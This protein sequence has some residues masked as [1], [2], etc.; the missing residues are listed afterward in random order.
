ML[1]TTT[2]RTRPGFTLVELMV[3]AAVCVLIMAILA[4]VF[5]LSIDTMRQMKSTGDLMTQLR[6]AGEVVKRDLQADHFAEADN[7]NK[8]SDQSL[9]KLRVD[10][11]MPI[12][13]PPPGTPG[14]FVLRGWS[15]PANGGFFRIK[16]TP[17]PLTPTPGSAAVTEGQ[18]GDGLLS[19]RATDHYLH[20]TSI[21]D[22]S[23]GNPYTAVVN[24][25]PYTKRAAEIAYFLDPT[26]SGTTGGTGTTKL[27]HLIR[28][29]RLAATS[30]SDLTADPLPASDPAVISV[31]PSGANYVVNTLADL[32]N[33]NNRL[34]G[35][36][37]AHPKLAAG[38]DTQLATI[39]ASPNLI[40]DDILISNVI[41]FEVKVQWQAN[42]DPKLPTSANPVAFPGN[43][44]DPFDALPPVPTAGNTT[45]TGQRVFDSWTAGSTTMANPADPIWSDLD[46]T[47]GS[48]KAGAN[49]KPNA[50]PLLIRVKAVQIH[51]RVFDPKLKTTRQMTIVQDL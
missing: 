9:D 10:D 26:E 28:R 50:I 14:R 48:F 5:Q 19:S 45:L 27:Y 37:G 47:S 1:R 44:D 33:P 4:T 40:G 15:P 16:S 29:Q 22:A 41:S 8:L 11:T 18:D 23:D 31:R 46:P 6:A 35:G 17:A 25:R 3:S 32:T 21:L 2:P 20:F 24:G 51:I 49:G 12:N 30:P 7:K 39:S 34:G 42:A 38:N 36:V 43:T 13:P